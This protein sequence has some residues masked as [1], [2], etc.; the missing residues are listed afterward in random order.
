MRQL[1]TAALNSMFDGTESEAVWL[2]L[3]TIDHATLTSPFHLVANTEDITSNG[4]LFTAYPFEVTLSPDDG[5]KLP[6]VQLTIDNVNRLLV[7]TIRVMTS[8]PKVTLTV[9]LA[10]QPN[11]AEIE[12]KNMI[13]RNVNYN[14]YSIT[15]TLYADD[16]LNAR[17]PE[18]DISLS[19]G[20]R[21]QFR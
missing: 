6:E 18:G 7:E 15:G 1:S 19:T 8:P 20:Y 14:A 21:G 5:T 10:A 11:V 16:I 9:V 12:I 17:F 3:L 2:V 4:D 13:L